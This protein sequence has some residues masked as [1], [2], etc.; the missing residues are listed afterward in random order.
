MLNYSDVE[1]MSEFLRRV[2]CWQARVV[3][4]RCCGDG[5]GGGG[6]ENGASHMFGLWLT[7]FQSEGKTG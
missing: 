6:E 2:Q 5:N 7:N 4:D 3:R 1:N